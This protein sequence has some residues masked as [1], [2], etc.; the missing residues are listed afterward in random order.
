[1]IIIWFL[2]WF[3]NGM[4]QLVFWNVWTI[5]GLFCAIASLGSSNK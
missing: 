2:V 5:T 3:G 4:P 1:M